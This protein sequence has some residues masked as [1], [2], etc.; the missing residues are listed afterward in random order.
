MTWSKAW[1][2]H[3]GISTIMDMT[4]EAMC[5]GREQD[6]DDYAKEIE[7]IQQRS[8]RRQKLWNK[9]WASLETRKIT[10]EMKQRQTKERI[11]LRPKWKENRKS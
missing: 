5:Q 9:A 1:P 2:S 10:A 6:M 3:E 11:R 4:M 8:R 7:D